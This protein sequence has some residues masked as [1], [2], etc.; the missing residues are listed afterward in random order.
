MNAVS[1]VVEGLA[2]VI[3]VALFVLVAIGAAVFIVPV[4]LVAGGAY[5]LGILLSQLFD[6]HRA[7]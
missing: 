6:E 2:T 1:I 5:F 7:R 3:G 4:L